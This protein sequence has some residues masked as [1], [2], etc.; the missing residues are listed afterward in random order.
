MELFAEVLNACP[1][2]ELLLK[3]PSFQE[4]DEQ[5]RILNLGRRVG[6]DCKRVLLDGWCN[7]HLEHLHCYRKVDLCLDPT[8]Y[9]GATTSVDALAMGVPV[10]TLRGR[11]SAGR[12]TASVLSHA[13]LS[14]WITENKS[15]YVQRALQAYEQGPRLLAQR[16][17]LREAISAS[18]FGAPARLAKELEQ[19]FYQKVEELE[20]SYGYF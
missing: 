3:S 7:S 20:R 18:S 13:G 10:V 9:S 19:L 11:S 12:L 17:C 6:L 16:Q 4:K 8:P 15:N 1:F 5:E 2:A 14:D